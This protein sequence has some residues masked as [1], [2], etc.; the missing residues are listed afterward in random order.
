VMFG[1]Q[2]VETVCHMSTQGVS[3]KSG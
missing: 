2:V 3:R 1:Y